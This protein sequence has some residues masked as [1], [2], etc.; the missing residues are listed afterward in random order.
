MSV[1]GGVEVVVD[2]DVELNLYLNLVTTFD[3]QSILV[4]MATIASSSS[5]PRA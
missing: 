5:M 2:G 1:D 3:G 4:S